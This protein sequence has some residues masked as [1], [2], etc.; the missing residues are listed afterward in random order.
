MEVDIEHFQVHKFLEET[1][2]HVPG[3]RTPQLQCL[4]GWSEPM[5]DVIH[6]GAVAGAVAFQG[7]RLCM[8]GYFV[9]VTTVHALQGV[10]MQVVG[11]GDGVCDAE[12]GESQ[13][14]ERLEM[15]EVD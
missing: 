12:H 15:W 13:Q 14:L 4:Y 2:I 7:D 1:K 3:L 8:R 6:A 5:D 10:Q 11:N 9:S